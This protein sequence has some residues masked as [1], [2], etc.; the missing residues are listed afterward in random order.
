MKGEVSRIS[1]E[2]WRQ[3]LRLPTPP[4]DSVKYLNLKLLSC[5]RF[6]LGVDVDLIDPSKVRIR[7]TK[8]FTWVTEL[9]IQTADT[10]SIAFSFYLKN[11]SLDSS[12]LNFT[13]GLYFS[14]SLSGKKN[15]KP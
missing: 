11:Y 12:V 10:A 4:P 14:C 9:E 1:L 2:G 8:G 6:F 13:L 15:Q 7:G 5:V 3:E